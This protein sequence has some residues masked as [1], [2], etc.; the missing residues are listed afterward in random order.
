M[1]VFIAFLALSFSGHIA[2]QSRHVHTH[3]AMGTEF[4]ITISATDTNGMAAAVRQSFARIDALEQSMSDYRA[5]SELNQLCG[6]TRWQ[7]VSPDLYKVLRFSRELAKQSEGAFDPTIG[8]LSKL[9]RR[10][11]R[12]QQFPDQEDILAARARVRWKGLKTGRQGQVRL[13]RE[14]MQLDLGGVAKGYALDVVGAILRDAGFPAFIVDGG[15]DLL[16]GDPPVGEAGWTVFNSA[17][18]DLSVKWCNIAIATSGDTYQYLD[19]EGIRYSHIIDP[20][21]GLGTINEW[22]VTVIGPAAMVADAL[23]STVCVSGAAV[24]SYYPEYDRTIMV[25]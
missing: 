23:A 13:R 5:D 9:W 25:H 18:I 4:R 15:G 21:T 17:M 14:N 24:F 22:E 2:C 8:P 7:T 1:R 3:P 10:A 19:S 12:Q 11:F 6:S 16:L 20:R